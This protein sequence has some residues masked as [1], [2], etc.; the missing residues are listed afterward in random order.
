MKRKLISAVC[1]L[2]ACVPIANAATNKPS[3]KSTP[4]PILLK[5]AGWHFCAFE[6]WL[7]YYYFKKNDYPDALR[8]LKQAEHH[9]ATGQDVTDAIGYSEFEIGNG[10][11]DKNNYLEA[12]AWFNKSINYASYKKD[13][14]LNIDAAYYNISLDYLNHGKPNKA[15]YYHRLYQHHLNEY[16]HLYKSHMKNNK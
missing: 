13:S 12:I 2:L 10:Y 6:K 16:K 5:M 8:W 7:G 15:A 3:L 9:G 4:N 1:I 11:F 14:M